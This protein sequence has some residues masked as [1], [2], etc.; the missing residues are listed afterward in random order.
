MVL[1]LNA[2]CVFFVQRLR[3]IFFIVDGVKGMVSFE[4]FN[5]VDEFQLNLFT[6]NRIYLMV[7][8]FYCGAGYDGLRPIFR[9]F[10]NDG[11]NKQYYYLLSIECRCRGRMSSNLWHARSGRMITVVIKRNPDISHLFDDLFMCLTT[12]H[13]ERSINKK[14]R[15]KMVYNILAEK[16]P[17]FLF[18]IDWLCVQNGFLLMLF[19]S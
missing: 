1:L 5:R 8:S 19:F 16:N 4:I 14:M 6:I 7:I 13:R 15:K 3:G 12:Y 2:G 9:R 18:A 17:L 10:S 11:L